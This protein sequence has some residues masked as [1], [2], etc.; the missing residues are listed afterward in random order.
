MDRWIDKLMEQEQTTFEKG[1]AGV[2]VSSVTFQQEGSWF[3]SWPW[4]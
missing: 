4:L 3:E 2:V 1:A